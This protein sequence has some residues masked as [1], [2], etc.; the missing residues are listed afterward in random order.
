MSNINSNLSLSLSGGVFTNNYR[1]S[2]P[3]TVNRV[4]SGVT[5]V[6]GRNSQP[7]FIRKAPCFLRSGFYSIAGASRLDL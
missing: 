5:P 2:A 6:L 7:V 3:F 1:L 4:H